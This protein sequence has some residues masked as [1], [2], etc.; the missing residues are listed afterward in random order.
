MEWSQIPA[1]WPEIE[2]LV[3]WHSRGLTMPIVA[4]LIPKLP[5]LRKIELHESVLAEDPDLSERIIEHFGNGEKLIV[6]NK[7]IHGNISCV[8]LKA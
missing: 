6:I 7:L 4:E 3:I 5:K 1:L 2:S 8:F